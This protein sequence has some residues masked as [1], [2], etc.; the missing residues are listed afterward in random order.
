MKNI[1][2]ECAHGRIEWTPSEKL[3]QSTSVNHGTTEAAMN[4][5]L[6]ALIHIVDGLADPK[7]QTVAIEALA[8]TFVVLAAGVFAIEDVEGQER[9]KA[10]R[11]N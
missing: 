3:A 9:A 6:C 11:N 2:F 5:V 8:G 4:D 1:V 10:A 7:T